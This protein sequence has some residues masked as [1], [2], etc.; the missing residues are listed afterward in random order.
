[1]SEYNKAITVRL[2]PEVYEK[3]QKV[4][5]TC[6]TS[7]GSIIRQAISKFLKEYE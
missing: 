1:M 2:K 7:R 5:E 3:L 6:E 4:A